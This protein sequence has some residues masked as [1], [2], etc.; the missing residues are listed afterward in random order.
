MFPFWLDLTSS[1]VWHTAMLAV[2]GLTM[3]LTH[4]LCLGGR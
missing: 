1:P 3:Y 4:T 2:T